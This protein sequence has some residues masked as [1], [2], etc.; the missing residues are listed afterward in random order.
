VANSKAL[1][2]AGFRTPDS[3][4]WGKVAGVGDFIFSNKVPGETLAQW[5]NRRDG[6]TEQRSQRRVLLQAVGIILMVALLI[7]PAAAARFW[8]YNLVTMTWIAAFIGGFSGVTGAFISGLGE[9]LPSGA[10]IVLT[11]SSCFVFSMF[12]GFKRGIVV[13]TRRRLETQKETDQ[14]HLLRDFFEIL[15]SKNLHLTISQTESSAELPL[16]K[17]QAKRV[18]QPSRFRKVI[19]GSANRGW[20][21]ESGDRV[22]LTARGAREAAKVVRRHRLWELYLIHF[23]GSDPSRVDRGADMIEHWL[24]P[25]VLAELESLLK[26]QSPPATVA[27]SPHPIEKEHW[28]NESESGNQETLSQNSRQTED[29]K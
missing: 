24:D 14:E 20:L 4:Y 17:L 16:G 18:W 5:L 1:S 2:F 7:T 21:V 23:A 28:E 29:P 13:R 27:S 19:N 15:E 26:E 3:I 25:D 8:T 11:A 22:Q 12:F 10:L 6:S 9:N